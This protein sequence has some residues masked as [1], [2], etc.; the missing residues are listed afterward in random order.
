MGLF[1]KV[2]KAVTNPAAAL[3]P[4]VLGS[5][6]DAYSAAEQARNV[7]KTNATNKHLA[8]EGMAFNAREAEKGR[9]FSAAQAKQ[10]MDFQERMSSTSYQRAMAD[11]K[12]AGLNP[13]L[14]YDQ[15]GAS[16]PGGAMASSPTASG[17]PAEVMPV[18]SRMALM[19]SNAKDMIRMYS[20][21][22][23]AYSSWK[24]VDS[25]TLKKIQETKNKMS[26]RN[27][28]DAEYQRLSM[29][30]TRFERAM[31]FEG[32]KPRLFGVLDAIT[33]RLPLFNSAVGAYRAGH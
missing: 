4:A 17:S 29:E 31:R 30:L 13:I 28:T 12:A 25:D 20:D 21:L 22:R 5:I 8:Y 16:T 1:K 24:N 6:G 2:I 23:S 7:E 33:K 27:V 26:E 15:G 10:Q 32:E 19:M 11:M 9:E 14:A 18:P 3:G